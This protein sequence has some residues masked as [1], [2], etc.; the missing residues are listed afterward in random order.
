MIKVVVEKDSD[1]LGTTYVICDHPGC[2][3][4]FKKTYWDMISAGEEG[5]FQKKDG[6]AWCPDHT[7]EW[8]A[9]W[10]ARQAEK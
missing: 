5:W 3:N 4:R 6:D 8:V 7:P 2:T 9:G 1:I 10:R